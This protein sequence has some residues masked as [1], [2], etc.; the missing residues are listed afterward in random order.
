MGFGGDDGFGG[1]FVSQ[2]STTGDLLPLLGVYR[3]FIL[4]KE[5]WWGVWVCDGVA[6]NVCWLTCSCVYGWPRVG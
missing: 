2:A 4:E 1:I 5:W 6:V 3:C